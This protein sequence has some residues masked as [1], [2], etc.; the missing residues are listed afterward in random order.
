[1]IYKFPEKN[2]RLEKMTEHVR[3]VVLRTIQETIPS[4]KPFVIHITQIIISPDLSSAKIGIWAEQ[5]IDEK[6]S[7]L[8]EKKQSFNKALSKIPSKRTPKCQFFI[9]H[10]YEQHQLL[11]KKLN[12][13]DESDRDN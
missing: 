1:M 5:D 8:N 10:E 2:R 12:E 9:D 4:S 6:I 11:L 7:L 13:T 3:R